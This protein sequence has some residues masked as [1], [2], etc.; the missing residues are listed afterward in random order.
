[1]KTCLVLSGKIKDENE[2]LHTLKK[3]EYPN[4]IGQ[5][6]QSVLEL[7]NKGEI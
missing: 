6:M 5:N 1:M 7:L 2:I 4:Y 3:E